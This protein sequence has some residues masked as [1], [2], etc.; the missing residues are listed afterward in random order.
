MNFYGTGKFCGDKVGM[1]IKCEA[2]GGI[3]MNH[4]ICQDMECSSVYVIRGYCWAVF[5]I[6]VVVH[7]WYQT[8]TNDG[9]GNGNMA[10]TVK[11]AVSFIPNSCKITTIIL[12]FLL[13]Y[14]FLLTSQCICCV[15]NYGHFLHC[16]ILCYLCVV[17]WLFL[18]GCQ[19]QC[20][21]LTGKKDSES[22]QNDL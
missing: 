19:Y 17:A 9:D 6:L 11:P 4:E 15:V 3:G 18:L 14:A 12:Q 5:T 2:A 7:D 21:W 10:G 8:Q 20:K 1:G 13:A 22:L 16:I